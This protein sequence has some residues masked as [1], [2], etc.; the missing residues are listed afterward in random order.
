MNREDYILYTVF[1][2]NNTKKKAENVV[3]L[4]GHDDE[5][6]TIIDGLSKYTPEIKTRNTLD[7]SLWIRL[8]TI[9]CV[10]RNKK[11]LPEM[12]EIN[13]MHMNGEFDFVL[14]EFRS[15]LH[16]TGELITTAYYHVN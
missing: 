9:G 4:R 13:L 8:Y 7:N 16:E 1:N 14:Y 15:Q 11:S 3:C 10:C 5:M 2:D 6:N 12:R